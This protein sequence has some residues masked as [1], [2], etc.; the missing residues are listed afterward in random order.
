M[1]KYQ[2]RS[3]I[4]ILKEIINCIYIYIHLSKNK[5]DYEMLKC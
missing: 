4:I 5:Y 1:V 2:S 3:L